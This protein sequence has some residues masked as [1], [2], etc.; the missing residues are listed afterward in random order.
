MACGVGH[1]AHVVGAGEVRVD[2]GGGFACRDLV[3]L[4]LGQA[5]VAAVERPQDL[6]RDRGSAVGG[7]DLLRDVA[8]LVEVEDARRAVAVGDDLL[9][10][11]DVVGV[12][13]GLA[14]GVGVALD[15]SVVEILVLDRRLARAG[16]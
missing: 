16:P 2:G 1:R 7:Q 5:V 15:P 3:R 13:D 10:A 6:L 12:G 14:E 11:G 8:P 4:G 9:A